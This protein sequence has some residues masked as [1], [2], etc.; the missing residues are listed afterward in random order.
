[1]K[2][3]EWTENFIKF[4]NLI[5]KNK[6]EFKSSLDEKIEVEITIK[7]NVEKEIYFIGD[8][9]EHLIPLLKN[10][11]KNKKY[12]LVCLNLK[13]NIESV[14][15]NWNIL[16]KI[17]NLYI[18]F[19]EPNKNEKWILKPHLHNKISDDETLKEGLFSLQN[20]LNTN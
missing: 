11:E 10:V 18:I 14:H 16:S 3:H 6:V 12:Y 5:R 19:V 7:G 1:M 9:I 20:S 8:K 4:R 15:N 17:E 13:E 2:L